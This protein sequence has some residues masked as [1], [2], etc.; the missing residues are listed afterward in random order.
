MLWLNCIFLYTVHFC[1][2]LIPQAPLSIIYV[3]HEYGKPHSPWLSEDGFGA[4][5][6]VH[7]PTSKLTL[8]VIT[9]WISGLWT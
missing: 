6:N 7:I 8:L 2:A 4:P 3:G 9:D 1:H 5:S